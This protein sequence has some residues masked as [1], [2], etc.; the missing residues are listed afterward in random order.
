MRSNNS[1][2][3]NEATMIDAVYEWLHK[4]YPVDTPK[5]ISVR[6]NSTSAYQSAQ[7]VEFTIGLAENEDVMKRVDIKP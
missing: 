4:R 7:S 5:V 1:M 2:V 6:A 3:L